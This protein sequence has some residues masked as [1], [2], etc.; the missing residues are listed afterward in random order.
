MQMTWACIPP[1]LILRRVRVGHPS[2]LRRQGETDYDLSTL[3]AKPRSPPQSKD[4]LRPVLLMS[5]VLNQCEPN[6]MFWRVVRGGTWSSSLAATDRK[7]G[8]V[9]ETTSTL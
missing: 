5:G 7:M 8:G 1:C 2:S 3:A 4:F 9:P 6:K